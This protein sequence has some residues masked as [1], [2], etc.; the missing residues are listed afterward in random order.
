MRL[1]VVYSRVDLFPLSSW[2]ALGGRALRE[3]RCFARVSPH[4]P[5]TRYPRGPRNGRNDRVQVFDVESRRLLSVIGEKGKLAP[6]RLEAPEGVAFV[7]G[8]PEVSRP[9]PYQPSP[10]RSSDTK[11]CSSRRSSSGDPYGASPYV[12]RECGWLDQRQTGQSVFEHTS[13]AQGNLVGPVRHACR[14][15]A[16][17]RRKARYAGRGGA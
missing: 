7:E 14:L 13:R 9:I 12:Y 3:T 2:R 1:V 5:V 4:D 15:L 8:R 6:G 10:P 16:F 11:S 17:G